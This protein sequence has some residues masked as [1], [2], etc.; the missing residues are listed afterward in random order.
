MERYGPKLDPCGTLDLTYNQADETALT[1]TLFSRS[2]RQL[3]NQ[4]NM[5]P[6]IPKNDC[7]LLGCV[8]QNRKQL[9]DR[10]KMYQ[11]ALLYQGVQKYYLVHS[12]SIE[13]WW[14]GMENIQASLMKDV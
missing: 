14:S 10:D 13:C 6:L 1:K 7:V 3:V 5:L 9:T 12:N 2:E 11:F 4:F 8:E